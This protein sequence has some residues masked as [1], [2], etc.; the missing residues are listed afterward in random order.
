MRRDDPSRDAPSRD[1]L[2]PEEK[3]QYADRAFELIKQIQG[4][5]QATGYFPTPDA[6]IEIAL[7]RLVLRSGDRFIDLGCGDGRVLIA[8]ARRGYDATGC[9]ADTRLAAH[10]A[11]R[12]ARVGPGRARVALGSFTHPG[13]LKLL[14]LG[15]ARGVFLFLQ[16]WALDQVMPLLYAGLPAGARVASYAFRPKLFRWRP[17]AVADAPGFDAEEEVRPLYLWR[18]PGPRPPSGSGGSGGGRGGGSGSGPRGG[19]YGPRGG[20]GYGPRGGGGY[21]RG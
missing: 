4:T 7:D 15:E 21:G 12:V 9:E 6:V 11:A 5:H 8:A 10:A 16:P 2:S 3:R 19:G 17:Y 18:A 20:G 14:G 1:A 13:T